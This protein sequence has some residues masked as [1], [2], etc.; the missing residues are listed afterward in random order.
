MTSPV[1]AALSLGLPRSRGYPG[2]TDPFDEPWTSGIF[3]SPVDGPVAL[4]VGGFDGDGQADLVNHGGGDKAVCA[5]S[6]GHYDVWR[7]L[8]GDATVSYGAFGENLTVEGLDE[9]TVCIGDVWSVGEVLVQVSQPRQPCWKLARKWRIRRFA[10][11][12]VESGRT[13][14]YFRVQR[15]GRVTRGDSLTVVDRPHPLWSVAAANAVM[16]DRVGDVGALVALPSLSAN[17]RRTLEKRLDVG[18]T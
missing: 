11:Q 12:V 10:E 15:E 16:H 7:R 3:K 1:I 6:A 18:T 17:W 2:A 13:G 8:L 14:W 9:S 4:S 5:Y